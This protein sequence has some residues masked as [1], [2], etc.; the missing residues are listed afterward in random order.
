MVNEKQDTTLT[1]LSARNI[2]V[3]E[4]QPNGHYDDN[5]QIDNTIRGAMQNWAQTRTHTGNIIME[6]V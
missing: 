3:W 6:T 2:V 1:T 5:N 4:Q